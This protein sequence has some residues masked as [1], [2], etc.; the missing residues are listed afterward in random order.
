LLGVGEGNLG[1]LRVIETGNLNMF[2]D[3]LRGGGGVLP[4]IDVRI[5]RNK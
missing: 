3:Q 5:S 1:G 4:E 2:T